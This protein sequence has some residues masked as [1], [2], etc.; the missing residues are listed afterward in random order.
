MSTARITENLSEAVTAAGPPVA[1]E[2]C[3]FYLARFLRCRGY[4]LLDL[5]PEGRRRRFGFRDRKARRNDVMAFY[6]N[7]VA[8][9]PP[10]Y[11]SA[12]TDKK[13]SLHNA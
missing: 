5:R 11:S 8:V 2:T 7:G 1:F 10:A 13:A 4:E 6:G 3:G 12:S 9:P